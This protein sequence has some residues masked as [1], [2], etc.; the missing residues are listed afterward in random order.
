MNMPYMT[1]SR[2][3]LSRKMVAIAQKMWLSCTGPV[4][5]ERALQALFYLCSRPLNA[6]VTQPCSGSALTT[7][8]SAPNLCD[9]FYIA[10]SSCRVVG[11]NLTY[12]HSQGREDQTVLRGP[13]LCKRRAGELIPSPVSAGLVDSDADFFGDDLG[14]YIFDHHEGNHGFLMLVDVP[15]CGCK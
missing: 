2:W 4:E 12:I 11:N 6:H 10:I 9:T 1:L 3:V 14:G 15:N 7:L 13:W 5:R 8:A